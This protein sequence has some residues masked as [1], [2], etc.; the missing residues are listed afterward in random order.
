MAQCSPD[1]QVYVIARNEAEKNESRSGTGKARGSRGI[2][3]KKLE[4]AL[5]EAKE[6]KRVVLFVD[7]VHF[8]YAACLGF[9]WCFQRVLVKSPS[10]R[11]RLNILGCL[12]AVTNEVLSVTEEAYINAKTVCTL[13]EKVA[14]SYGGSVPITI[15]LD[16]ARYQRCNLVRLC[17]ERL[18]IELSFLPSYSPNLNLIE[19][20][21]KWLKKT[22]LY[23]KYYQD[24]ASLQSI[25]LERIR[26]MDIEKTNALKTL[27][28]WR[29]ESLKNIYQ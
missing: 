28:T 24:F 4:P 13:L 5:Q 18:G 10:G 11:K 22:C 2:S 17:A 9:F 29:F 8:L 6:G 3:K 27:L 21:W 14:Q 25:V 19:R 23:S 12:N 7:A 26:C 20:Y 15:I 16:N 1:S